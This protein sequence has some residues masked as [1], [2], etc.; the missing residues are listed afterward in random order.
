MCVSDEP[1]PSL[2]NCYVQHFVCY[3]ALSRCL[4]W[5][6]LSDCAPRMDLQPK[7]QQV[8]QQVEQC[9]H[10]PHLRRPCSRVSVLTA[11]PALQGSP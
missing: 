8:R 1:P 11:E 2:A 9:R 7:P 10:H 3:N 4:H 6:R 5:L